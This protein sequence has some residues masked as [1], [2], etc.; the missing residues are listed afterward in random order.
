M[1]EVTLTDSQDGK[2]CPVLAYPHNGADHL[3]PALHLVIGHLED[4][5]PR[6]DMYARLSCR[7]VAGRDES[8]CRYYGI[9][10]PDPD[11]LEHLNLYLR[12]YCGLPSFLKEI[13]GV[14]TV[15]MDVDRA[16][17]TANNGY[18]IWV[19]PHLPGA[20]R[21]LP[22]LKW[23][24]NETLIKAHH[25]FFHYANI[26]APNTTSLNVDPQV[27][28]IGMLQ[29]DGSSKTVIAIDFVGARAMVEEMLTTGAPPEGYDIEVMSTEDVYPDVSA[30]EI[31]MQMAESALR[32]IENWEGDDIPEEMADYIDGF[33]QL[34]DKNWKTFIIK[35]PDFGLMEMFRSR[36]A[37]V[38]GVS[39]RDIPIEFN[40]TMRFAG[41]CMI[42]IDY[43]R[44]AEHAVELAK[45]AKECAQSY[46][47]F[48]K[49]ALEF[50]REPGEGKAKLS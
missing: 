36:V 26:F 40:P 45:V 14:P 15:T 34:R 46:Q 24:Q 33:E 5:F 11:Y 16:Y 37:K 39:P 12:R 20:A 23:I 27:E 29:K 50:T 13:D 25:D 8:G 35:Q 4:V 22:A 30:D 41:P 17:D 10:H 42:H 1:T 49:V 6:F 7:Y 3:P 48:Q 38:L 9:Q 31:L 47:I 32:F 21:V 19:S 18:G 44:F 43:D 2:A 28:L